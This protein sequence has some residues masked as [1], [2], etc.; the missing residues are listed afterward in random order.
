LVVDTSGFEKNGRLVL[1]VVTDARELDSYLKETIRDAI[2]RE[3]SPRHVP[4]IIEAI[5]SVP[6]TING[7][8]MEVPIRKAFG[9]TFLRDAVSEGSMANPESIE[10][11][12]TV[13][14]RLKLQ[15]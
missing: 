3:L 9:A 13:I 14:D 11:L 7:K 2:R 15:R 4:D 10:D 1:F 6:R 12:Q 8:K 5:Q